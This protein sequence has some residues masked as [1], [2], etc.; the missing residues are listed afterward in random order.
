MRFVIAIAGLLIAT[1]VGSAQTVDPALIKAEKTRTAARF[2]GDVETWNRYI[3]DD[4]VLVGPNGQANTKSQRGD[5]IRSGK[6][7]GIV[8]QDKITDEKFRLY[9]DTT[10]RS[11]HLQGPG[12]GVSYLLEVWV[13]QGGEWKLAHAQFTP[14]IK[15]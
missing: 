4:F 2:A 6:T 13:K 9:G 15:K 8:E 12:G 3:T 14:I 5:L 1:S 11:Y 10:I 7:K